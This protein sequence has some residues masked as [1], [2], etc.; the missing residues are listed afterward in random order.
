MHV[1]WDPESGEDKQTWQFDSGDVTRKQ[2]TLIEKHYGGSYDQWLAGL[3]GGQIQARTVLLWYMLLQVH[4]NI[5]FEDIPDFRVRQLTVQ[6]GVTELRDLW[7]KVQRMRLSA[8]ER[9]AFEAQFEEDMRDAMVR[10]G[11]DPSG[12]RIDGKKLELEG[13]EGLPKPQ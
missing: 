12:V 6:M 5:K 10:E 11:R 2:A 3:M 4:S 8:D 9:E 7:K 1:E 13:V